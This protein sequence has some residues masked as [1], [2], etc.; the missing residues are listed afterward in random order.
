MTDFD[1]ASSENIGRRDFLR[2][3]AVAI[4]G[5]SMVAPPM[6]RQAPNA[7]PKALDDPNII[8]GKVWFPSGS[9]TIDGYLSHPKAKGIFPIVIVVAGNTI[10]EEYIP[11]TTAMLAQAGFAGLAPNIYSLQV[12]TMTA[13]E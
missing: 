9:E 7:P 8:H 10:A 12:E 11:N 13:A 6:P 2:G 3:G 1:E 4:A 5:A